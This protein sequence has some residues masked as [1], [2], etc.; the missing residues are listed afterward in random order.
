MNHSINKIGQIAVP[1]K[2]FE[3]AV[4]FYETVLEVPKLFE[5][6]QLAFFDCGG[7]RLLLSPPEKEE[8]ATASSVIYFHVK[9]IEEAY[10]AFKEKGVRFTDEPHL[11][12]KMGQTETWM[13]FFTDSEDNTLALMSEKIAAE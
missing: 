7:V 5:A 13:V 2:N 6:G 4:S 9:H 1:V 10:T 12:A 11:I 8:F 3:R